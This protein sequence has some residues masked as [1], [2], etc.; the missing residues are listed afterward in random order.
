[1]RASTGKRQETTCIQISARRLA[2]VVAAVAAQQS[3][4]MLHPMQDSE[5][6]VQRIVGMM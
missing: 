4:K 6:Q 1:M 5:A 2:A 3:G